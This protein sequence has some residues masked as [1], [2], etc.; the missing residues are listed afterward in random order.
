MLAALMGNQKLATYITAFIDSD[1]LLK[2]TNPATKM[3]FILKLVQ[4]SSG[5]DTLLNYLNRR[6]NGGYIKASSLR[7]VIKIYHNIIKCAVESDALLILLY[8]KDGNH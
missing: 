3:A 5:T 1:N 2:R 6:S 8:S 7:L 4:I